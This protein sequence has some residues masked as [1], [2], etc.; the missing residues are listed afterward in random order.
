MRSSLINTAP[1]CALELSGIIQM[2]KFTQFFYS[3]MEN[4]GNNDALQLQCSCYVQTL[5]KI[6]KICLEYVNIDSEFS[7]YTYFY[8]QNSIN[9]KVNRRQSNIR[10]LLI[11]NQCC[12]QICP[13][14]DSK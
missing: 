3:F 14:I 1:A 13:L 7:G 10:H 2:E 9:T 6:R 11:S 5:Q 12:S 8:V 4:F